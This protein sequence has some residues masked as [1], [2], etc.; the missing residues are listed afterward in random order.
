M[1]RSVKEPSLST[2][3]ATRAGARERWID[4]LTALAAWVALPVALWLLF[5]W[6]RGAL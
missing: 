3:T 6:L 4:A 1:L 2:G 5:A